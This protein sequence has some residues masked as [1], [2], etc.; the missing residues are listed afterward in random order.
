MMQSVEYVPATNGQELKNKKS[1]QET[2][3][4]D[5]KS[6]IEGSFF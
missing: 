3:T 1:F 4:G 6:S 2:I 5:E